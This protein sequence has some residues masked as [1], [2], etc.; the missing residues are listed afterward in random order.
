MT[1]KKEPKTEEALPK[2]QEKQRL[3]GI[4]HRLVRKVLTQLDGAQK[5]YK[6]AFDL[7]IKPMT[8]VQVGQSVYIDREGPGETDAFGVK[9]RHK[10]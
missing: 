1:L 8:P 4:I 6:L 10:L 9:H 7:R 5:L 3:L 2:A